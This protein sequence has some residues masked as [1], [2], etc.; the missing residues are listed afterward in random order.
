LVPRGDL[1][2]KGVGENIHPSVLAT[3]IKTTA[4]RRLAITD[5]VGH[6]GAGDPVETLTIPAGMSFTTT[7]PLPELISLTVLGKLTA[8]GA[9]LAQVTDL[10]VAGEL[11]AASALYTGLTTLTVSGTF[12]PPQ[13]LSGLTALTVEGPLGNFSAP[14]V[15]GAGAGDDAGITLAVNEG[16]TATITGGIGNLKQGTI[17][18][19]LTA[20][21][22]TPLTPPGGASTTSPLSALAGAVINGVPFRA[23]TTEVTKLGP[24]NAEV[25]TGNFAVAASQ[26]LSIPAGT[27]LTIAAGSTFTYNGQVEIAA[28]GKLVLATG[29]TT[30]KIVGTGTITAGATVITGNWEGT[31]AADGTLEI[32]SADVG[33]TI[34]AATG[35]TGLK[36]TAAGATIIQNASIAN[37]ALSL[38][39][40][41]IDLAATTNTA[42]VGEIL[43]KYS[44]TAENIAKLSLDTTSKV[45]TGSVAGVAG[46]DDDITGVTINGV[47]VATTGLKKIDFSITAAG[48]F[49]SQFGGNNAGTI[50]PATEDIVINSTVTG[51]VS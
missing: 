42:K 32:L 15:A 26:A 22:F 6:I 19:T 31:G 40:T 38:V 35:A 50:K 41:T 11:V 17:A 14:S 46:T 12:A 28:T 51:E 3:T 18:G 13:A 49:L 27:T 24:T 23:E 21:G 29:A 20:T 1:E 9:K 4:T 16:G 48:D 34:T 10:N 5:P 47:T 2:L 44:A 43:L 30:P 39:T 33:A 45:V 37:S 36:A 25:T 8:N 7:D